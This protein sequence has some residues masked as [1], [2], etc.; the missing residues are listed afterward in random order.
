ML[1]KL[2]HFEKDT[3]NS[4]EYINEATGDTDKIMKGRYVSDALKYNFKFQ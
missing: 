1:L 3:R 2:G 4:F